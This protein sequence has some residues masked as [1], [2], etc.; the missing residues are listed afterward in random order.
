MSNEL[1]LIKKWA[2]DCDMPPLNLDLL[3]AGDDAEWHRAWNEKGLWRLAFAVVRSF[4][5]DEARDRDR[6]Q[7]VEDIA[8]EAVAE[9]AKAVREGRVN[10]VDGLRG[11]L[12][13]I[14]SN[15]AI[16]RI[17]ERWFNVERELPRPQRDDHNAPA[18]QNDVQAFVEAALADVV[19]AVDRPLEAIIEEWAEAA[20][21]DVLEKALFR[22]HIAH[23]C[24][25]Q[26]F[27]DAH[28]VPLGTVGGLKRE[29]MEKLRNLV[30]DER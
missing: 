27:A 12:R 16:D 6:R 2:E 23:H 1:G 26:E 28:H 3:R 7:F 30:D 4:F 14:A 20:K 22:E 9:L 18:N 29:V 17:R 21:L 19:I 5:I 8:L 11:M 15:R 10:N 24:T 13:T 25:Q